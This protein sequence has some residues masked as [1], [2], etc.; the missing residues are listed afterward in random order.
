MRSLKLLLI[1]LLFAAPVA[2]QP[3]YGHPQL[4]AY[5]SAAEWP[6]VNGQCWKGDPDPIQA[7]HVHIIPRGPI[8]ATIFDYGTLDIPFTLQMHNIA[9]R[10]AALTGEHIRSVRW[11]ATGT[12][13]VPDLAGDPNGLKEWTGV[14]T[15]DFSI[16]PTTFPADLF[17]FPVHGWAELRFFTRTALDDGRMLDT[18]ITLP[19]YSVIDPSAPVAPSAEQGNPGVHLRASC[20]LWQNGATAAGE[21]VMEISDYI[22]LLPIFTP[23]TT[24]ANAYNYTAPAGVTFADEVFDQVLDPNLH[25]GVRGTLQR[26]IKVGSGGNKQFLGPIVF[27][28]ALMGSGPRK[29]MTVWTQPL[30]SESVSAVIVVPVTVGAGVPPP[31]ALC[32]DPTAPNVGQPLPCLPPIIITPPPTPVCEDPHATNLGG[33]LPCVFPPPVVTPPASLAGVYTFVC[34]ALGKC[35][36]TVIKP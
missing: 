29:E 33:A 12:T 23:W 14:A 22:P 7:S 8:Y 16:N 30:G 21:V 32:T 19:M 34:D 13:A 5:G 20:T 26:E 25:M 27:D 18:L 11:D 4:G 6:P 9:G 15:F 17:K 31:P 35:Q 10:I 36:L 2:A 1:A 24:I 3:I 28:P